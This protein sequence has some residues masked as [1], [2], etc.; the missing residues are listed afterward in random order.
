MTVFIVVYPFWSPIR[1][2][3]SNK[4]NSN[5]KQKN[6][7]GAMKKKIVKANLLLIIDFKCALMVRIELGRGGRS[8]VHWISQQH[9]RFTLASFFFNWFS[10]VLKLQCIELNDNLFMDL[11]CS[12]FFLHRFIYQFPFFVLSFFRIKLRVLL[13]T[14]VIQPTL[15]HISIHF[16]FFVYSSSQQ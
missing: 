13:T 3:F 16:T 4:K 5:T 9:R 7:N 2:R 15:N 11:F 8:E 12:F 14:S 6:S 1:I 10:L